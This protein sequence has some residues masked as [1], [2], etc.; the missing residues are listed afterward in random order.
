MPA[1]SAAAT[2]APPGQQKQGNGGLTFTA[3]WNA[4]ACRID[5]VR[6]RGNE[7]QPEEQAKAEAAYLGAIASELRMLVSESADQAAAIESFG[8]TPR[9]PVAVNPV[10]VGAIVSGAASESV[11]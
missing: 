4:F 1:A 5:G 11:Q 6:Q 8:D 3:Q 7:I 10:T 2:A 9:V